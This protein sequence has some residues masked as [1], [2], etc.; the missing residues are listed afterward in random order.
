MRISER[1]IFERKQ[2][3]YSQRALAALAGVSNTT[4][5]R[6]EANAVTPDTAT[7]EKLAKALKVPALQLMGWTDE[8]T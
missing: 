1:L 2:Q 7:I 8:P 3:R 5:A 4:I 6:I